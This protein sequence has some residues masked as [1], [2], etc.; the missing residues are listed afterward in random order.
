[1]PIIQTK[2]K[3]PTF[4]LETLNPT[5]DSVIPTRLNSVTI[6]DMSSA[7]AYNI[8]QRNVE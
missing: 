4:R 1:M 6:E 5:S 3:A 2:K 8:E 7:S